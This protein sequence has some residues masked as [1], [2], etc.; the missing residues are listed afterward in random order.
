MLR[1]G[2]TQRNSLMKITD[3]IKYIDFKVYQ[4]LP[5]VHVFVLEMGPIHNLMNTMPC[6]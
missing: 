2:S 6:Q 1:L 3:Q 5:I 4:K